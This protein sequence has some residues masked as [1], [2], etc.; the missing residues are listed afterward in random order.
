M[1]PA[2]HAEPKNIDVNIQS[3]QQQLEVLQ[4]Q[5]ADLKRSQSDQYADAKKQVEEIQN[6]VAETDKKQKASAA[7]TLKNGRP[8]FSTADGDFTASLRGNLQAD[9][10][11]YMQ[12]AKVRSL[13][14]GPDLSSGVNIRRAQL[15]L[16]GVVFGEWSYNFNYDF[17]GSGYE[18]PGKILN[19]YLQYDGLAPFAVRFGAFAP[20]FSVEDQTASTDLMFLERNSPTNMLRNVA[21]SEGRVG[22]SLIYAGERLFGA[23]SY[24]GSKIAET[25]AYDEQQAAIGRLAYLAVND[26]ESDAHLLLGG[27]FIQVIKLSDLV[28]NG[29]SS[30]PKHSITLSDYPEIAVDDNAVKLISTGALA[31]N[32]FTS[33]GFELAGN[34]RNFYIQGAYNGILID[35]ASAYTVYTASGVSATQTLPVKN[36]SLSSWY[37]QGS[38]IVTGESKTYVPATGAFAMP[39]PAKPFSL[40][41]GT[42]GAWEIAARY[43][44]T[45]LNDNMSDASSYIS[46]WSGSSKTYTFYNTV[47]GGDQKI[48]TIGVNWYPNNAVRFMLDYMWID[49]GRK[50]STASSAKLPTAEI[51]QSLQAASL[52]AQLA[53]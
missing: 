7:V 13:S 15:G 9:Y 51:G 2:A 31:A 45:N 29:G 38:W 3:L 12:S 25:G 27:N 49:V 18:T 4:A 48:Y 39:K 11:Y 17:G 52:R 23:L 42:W 36:S 14:T 41:D 35:R 20:S 53:F 32:H 8:T 30:N 28:A 34:Y 5:I 10:G 43:S 22:A 26:K 1:T 16:Q 24:T 46:A 44:D 19:A 50:A 33:W 21:G 6:K 40:A 47:R 37:L